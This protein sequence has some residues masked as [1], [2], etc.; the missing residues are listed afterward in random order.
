MAF[1]VLARTVVRCCPNCKGSKR[2]IFTV[3]F[4]KNETRCCSDRLNST[5]PCVGTTALTC[6]TSDGGLPVYRRLW[7]IADQKKS[8]LCRCPSSQLKRPASAPQQVSPVRIKIERLELVAGLGLLFINHEST[9]GLAFDS[10]TSMAAP[11]WTRSSSRHR[12]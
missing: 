12:S 2:S 1:T 7:M 10:V 11:A 6:G 9:T 8:Q 5:V 4:L 3:P